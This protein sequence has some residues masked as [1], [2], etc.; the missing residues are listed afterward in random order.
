MFLQAVRG[1]RAGVENV[2]LV[3]YKM[4]GSTA[5]AEQSQEKEYDLDSEVH[6]HVEAAEYHLDSE[7]DQQGEA[8][9]GP[10]EEAGV[11]ETEF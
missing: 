10:S 2:V 4:V 11:Q 3:S 5:E 8:A 6:L 7:E 9:S 1:Q